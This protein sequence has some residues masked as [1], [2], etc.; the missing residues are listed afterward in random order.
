VTRRDS[1]S[2]GRCGISGCSRCCGQFVTGTPCGADAYTVC[3]SCGVWQ[4]MSVDEMS[5]VFKMNDI[6]PCAVHRSLFY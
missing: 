3:P 5:A 4:G 6:G 2:C 1:S